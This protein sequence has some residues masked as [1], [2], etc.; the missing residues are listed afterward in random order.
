MEGTL[1]KGRKEGALE[2]LS[3]SDRL[4]AFSAGRRP[5]SDKAKA[6]KQPSVRDGKAIQ[7]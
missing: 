1:C 6:M 7:V 3:P 4:R 5:K 2:F